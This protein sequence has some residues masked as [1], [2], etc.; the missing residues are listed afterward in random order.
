[1]M[2]GKLEKWLSVPNAAFEV[3]LLEFRLHI[4]SISEH[5]KMTARFA[6]R[7]ARCRDIFPAAQESLT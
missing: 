7:K 2:E 3:C 5:V 6:A 4:Q 1:M